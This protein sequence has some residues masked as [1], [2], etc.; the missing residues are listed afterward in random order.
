ML[1][2]VG[3]FA[4]I[5]RARVGVVAGDLRSR[6]AAHS[7]G[8]GAGAGVAVVA[9]GPWIHRGGDA[10]SGLRHARHLGTGG[11][12]PS[13]ANHGGAGLRLAGPFDA[14]PCAQ[15]LVTGGGAVAFRIGGAGRR[16]SAV[17]PPCR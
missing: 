17:A 3:F 11:V 9:G 14:T 15:A 2:A 7:A 10:G 1:A 6:A 13:V 5:G 8:I 16:S 12:V 4:G